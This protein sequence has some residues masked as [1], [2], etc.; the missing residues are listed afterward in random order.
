MK[1][2][3]LIFLPLLL[4]AA[5]GFVLAR[6]ITVSKDGKVRSLTEALKVAVSHDTITIKEGRYVEFNVKIDKPVTIRGEGHVVIDGDEK[7]YVLVV[8]SDSVIIRDIEVRNAGRSFIEDYAGILVEQSHHGLIENVKV[9]NN[10]FGIYLAKSS[11]ITLRNNEVHST[12]ERESKSGN[13]IHLWYS[14]NI[15][16]EGNHV[17][18]HRDGIYFEF[19]EQGTIRDNRSEQNLR[20]GLH[21][22]FSDD[23]RYSKNIFENNGAGVAVMFTDNVEMTD[24]IF[25][26]NWGSAAY[27]LLLKE[28]YDSKVE[29][30]R[31]E[32]NSIGI[33]LE[34]SNRISIKENEFINNGWAVKLMANS[35]DNRFSMNNFIGNT[36]EVATNSRQHFNTFENNYWSQY[37]GYDL[38]R[39][40]IGDVPHRPVRLFSLMVERHPQ[41][42]VLLHSLLVK[43]LDM[44]ERLMPAL[45]PEA[46]ID[47]HP[48]MEEIS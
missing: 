12:A 42:L 16:I 27:G 22:M 20:Y 32:S 46:L 30:N 6:D 4:L 13:G 41:T 7:G 48:R 40:G 24:N 36:F 25:R 14:K 35:M 18:G 31:F 26:N 37:E 11:Y 8:Q 17:S 44:A 1:R 3:L 38:D 33:Y 19:V 43:V 34:A 45:T 39:D 21:F 47:D 28:I 5:P 15:T 9:L 2:L 23:C 29:N 10:F